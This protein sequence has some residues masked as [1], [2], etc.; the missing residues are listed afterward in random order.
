M[1]SEF[2]PTD[3]SPVRG[4]RQA[5]AIEALQQASKLRREKATRKTIEA[6]LAAQAQAKALAST[7]QGQQPGTSADGASEGAQAPGA[8][9]ALGS[10]GAAAL[11][12][13]RKGSAWDAAKKTTLSSKARGAHADGLDGLG[14]SL[15]FRGG[16][17]MKI[18]DGQLQPQEERVGVRRVPVQGLPPLRLGERGPPKRGGGGG[19]GGGGG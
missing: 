5:K 1:V 9:T 18:R 11:A 17:E 12:R 15:D 3:G 10:G 8:S 6:D 14:S 7:L 2:V 13:M 19:G 16:G 4:P